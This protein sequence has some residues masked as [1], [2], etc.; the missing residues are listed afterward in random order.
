[1]TENSRKI[2]DETT[3]MRFL[4]T[5]RDA[6]HVRRTHI[7]SDIQTDDILSAEFT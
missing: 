7:T 2:I 4:A 6:I 3:V 5:L 1:M